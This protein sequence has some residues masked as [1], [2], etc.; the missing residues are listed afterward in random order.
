MPQTWGVLQ[1]GS[2]A[3][4]LGSATPGFKSQLPSWLTSGTAV[5]GQVL[6]SQPQ[7]RRNGAHKKSIMRV[8]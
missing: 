2:G 5:S 7:G 4:L 1:K 6:P 8:L 3:W